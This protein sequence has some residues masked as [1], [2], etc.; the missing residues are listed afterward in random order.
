MSKLENK[1][2]VGDLD[3]EEE[4]NNSEE[5]DIMSMLE[6]EKLFI[7]EKDF[8]KKEK[9]LELKEFVKVMLKHLNYSAQYQEND[10]GGDK[11]KP[12]MTDEEMKQDITLRLI[13]LF[14]EIDVNGDE[15]MEWEEFSNHIIELGLLRKDRTFRNVIKKYNPSE[16]MIN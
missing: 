7:I 9:G 14:K 16:S 1:L 15:T 11:K 5:I 3:K 6:K 12:S 2:K 4:E 10:R 13:D 8:H